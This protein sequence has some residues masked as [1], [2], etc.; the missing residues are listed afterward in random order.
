[1]KITI[2]IDCT[3]EEAR[4]FFGL[5][6][7]RPLND[8]VMDEMKRR[9]EKGFDAEDIDKA[10]KLWMGGANTGLGEFQKSMWNMMSGMAGTQDTSKDK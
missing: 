6:D 1:M 8:A 7:V 2:D 3:P 4:T 9:I 5:P 10:I